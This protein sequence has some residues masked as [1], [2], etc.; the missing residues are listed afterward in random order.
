MFDAADVVESMDPSLPT[1]PLTFPQ[2]SVWVLERLN[3]GTGICNVAATMRIEEDLDASF[4]VQAVNCMLRRNA[5]FHLRIRQQGD[6]TVQYFAPCEPYALPVFDFREADLE[7]FYAWDTEQTRIPFDM[8]DHDLFFFALVRIRPGVTGFYVRC[9]HAIADA[10]SMVQI[11]NE[12]VEYYHLLKTGQPLPEEPNPS[13]ADF[14]RSEQD[15]FASPRCESDR[16]FWRDR[17]ATPPDA[18]SL[19]ALPIGRASLDARRKTFLLPDRLVRRIK[20]HCTEHRT[21]VFALFYSTLAIY[22]NRVQNAEDV[23]FGTPVL[24]RTNVREKKT[25]G[26]FISTVPLR[27][28]IDG[29][30]SFQEFARTVDSEWFSVLKHQKYPYDLLL[31]DIRDTHKDVDKLFDI[32]VSYQNAKMVKEG[33]LPHEESRWH[34]NG[35]QIE[36]LYLHINDREDDG[37]LVLNYDYRTDLYFA[38]EID[39]LHEHLIQLLWHALDNPARRISEIH[40]LGEKER[41]KVLESFNATDALYP[42]DATIGGLFSEQVRQRPDA[43]ALVHGT[44]TLSYRDLD[45]RANRLANLLRAKGVGPETPVALLLPRCPEMVIGILGVVKAGGAY[46]PIDPDYPSERLMT[47]LDDCRPRC[48]VSCA[49]YLVGVPAAPPLRPRVDI[50]LFALLDSAPGPETSETSPPD[51]NGPD[52]LLYVIYTSGTTGRPKGAQIEHRNVVRLLFNDRFAF[53]FGPADCWSLFHSYCF[54]F[55]VWEMYGALLYGGTLVI[56]TK[57]VARDP[58]R[59]LDLLVRERVTILNQTPAAFYNLSDA[60]AADPGK[61]LAVRTVVF[62]GD[63]LKPMLLKPFRALYPHAKLINMYGITETTVHVTYLELSDNDLDR[64]V[65]NIGRPIPGM[66]CYILDSKLNP[67]PIGVPGELCVG[68]DGVGRGYLGHPDLTSTKFVPDP[69]RPGGLL[70]RSGDL[71]R[72]YPQG[73]MEY[74]GRIDTQVKIRG[75]RIELGEVETALLKFDRV[76]KAAV[77]AVDAYDGSRRLCAYY[78][79]SADFDVVELRAFLTRM[80]PDYM[81]PAFFVALKRIPLNSNGKIDRE[82][83]PAP[84]DSEVAASLYASVAYV[85]PRNELEASIARIWCEALKQSRIGVD[86]DFFQSGGDSLSA[87]VAISRMGGRASFGDLYRNPTVALLAD[88]IVRKVTEGGSDQLIMKLAGADGADRTH[89]VCFP[90]GG[91]NA[92]VFKDLADA[93][94]RRSSRHCVYAVDLPGRIDDGTTA[95]PVRSNADLAAQLADEICA[96]ISGEVV[97][98]AHCVGNALALETTRLLRRRGIKVRR[99][100]AGAILPPAAPRHLREGHDPW[101]LVPDRGVLFF[102]GRLGLPCPDADREPLKVLLRA[103]RSDVRSY[104]DYFRKRADLPEKLDVPIRSIVGAID[105]FTFRHTRRHRRWYRYADTVDRVVLEGASH[106]FMKTHVEELAGILLETQPMEVRS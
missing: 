47:L 70:Y 2:N 19:K 59:F 64:N 92:F 58:S 74:L 90:Y 21:S 102:L 40:M 38:K 95:A 1:Y 33:E 45:A 5:G 82:R 67:Q 100:F 48:L 15:Y 7:R 63:A 60:I 62:G 98:Y 87:V 22:A 78:V 49:D 91:G 10:W 53:D 11:A 31:K 51:V 66:R 28:R 52:D 3:P 97:I 14:I 96:M 94:V 36:S 99:F 6:R 106:Y 71:A 9:H 101:R 73:D 76:T 55:S 80:L 56:V 81:L 41:A 12:M 18:T 29:E 34:F 32:A 24:N 43:P 26:M 61:K 88:A 8:D 46:I 42:R 72:F 30:Q 44:R 57:E 13:Y 20:A 104:Y 16:T 105:P 17:Y 39:F 69:F 25:I 27:T 93:V 103:F 83:L 4:M 89:V 77:A 54:D 68:G 79:P 23:V 37:R 65:S 35:Y 75:H 84:D 85:A 50:D 86:D